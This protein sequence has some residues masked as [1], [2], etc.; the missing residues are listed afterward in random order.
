MKVRLEIEA[1]FEEI[2]DAMRRYIIGEIVEA[3]AKEINIEDLQIEEVKEEEPEQEEEHKRINIIETAPTQPSETESKLHVAEEL[4]IEA[5]P[6][7]KG[8]KPR[9][10]IEAWLSKI[11]KTGK[12]NIPVELLPDRHVERLE[13][14]GLVTEVKSE[15]NGYV[16]VPKERYADIIKKVIFSE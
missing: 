2:A 13:R 12:I 14:W 4:I 3:L 1:E 7:R 11:I 8:R 6:P 10:S 5:I 16:L 9:G 15:G